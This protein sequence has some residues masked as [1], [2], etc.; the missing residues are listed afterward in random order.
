VKSV[1]LKE[2]RPGRSYVQV[3]GQRF[4]L[5]ETVRDVSD[6]VLEKLKAVPGVKVHVTA[7]RSDQ[8]DPKTGGAKP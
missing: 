3:G 2:A 6:D 8:S 1:T 4:E 5:G 7:P